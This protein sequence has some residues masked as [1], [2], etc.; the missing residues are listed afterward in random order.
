MQKGREGNCENFYI[1]SRLELPL[2]NK[3][4]NQVARTPKTQIFEKISKS[5]SMTR[6]LTC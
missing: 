4:P 3:S 6:T 1:T 2:V 5:F